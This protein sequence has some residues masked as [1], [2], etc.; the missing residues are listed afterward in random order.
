M[1]K[2]PAKKCRQ[3]QWEV[4]GDCSMPWTYKQCMKCYA[5]EKESCNLPP[6]PKAV[7]VS[8]FSLLKSMLLSLFKRK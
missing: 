2:L 4:R 7:S 1:S 6:E 5:T 3:A 8:K